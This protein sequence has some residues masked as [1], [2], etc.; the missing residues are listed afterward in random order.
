MKLCI[1]GGTGQQG[2]QQ[3]LAGLE[4]GHGNASAIEPDLVAAA[5]SAH[6]GTGR[7]STPTW[8]S[9]VLKATNF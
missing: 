7:V 8:D 4:Q 1:I 2:Y 6:L 3:V 9:A 5:I